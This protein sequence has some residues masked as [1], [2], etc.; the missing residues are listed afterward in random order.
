MTCEYCAL[1]HLEAEDDASCLATRL[2]KAEAARD[3]YKAALE[4]YGQHPYTCD[5]RTWWNAKDRPCDCGLE[6]AKADATSPI[7]VRLVLQSQEM[8][9]LVKK[10]LQESGCDGDLCSRSWHEEF[11]DLIRKV[12]EEP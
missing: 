9:D 1:E 8:F 5:S 11:R 6:K 3:H 2:E 4:T 12:E 7:R 10:H